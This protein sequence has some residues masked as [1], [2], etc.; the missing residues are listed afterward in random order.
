M[1]YDLLSSRHLRHVRVKAG[2]PEMPCQTDSLVGVWPAANWMER[3]VFNLYGVRF[4]DH[5]DLRRILLYEKFEGH[6]LCKDPLVG[7]RN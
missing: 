7:P 3:E 6:L 1:V 2:V 5:P 4:P